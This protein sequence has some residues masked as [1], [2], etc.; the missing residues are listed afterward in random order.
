MSLFPDVQRKAQDEVDRVVGPNRLP[1][2]DDYENLVYIKAVILE[3]MRWM[4]VVALNV[5][6]YATADNVYKGLHIPKGATILVVS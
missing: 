4:P 6:H 3:T 5:P 1:V 2:F